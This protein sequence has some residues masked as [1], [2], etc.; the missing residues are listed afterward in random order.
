MEN[1]NYIKL[2]TVEDITEILKAGN[3]NLLKDKKDYTGKKIPSFQKSSNVMICRAESNKKD[4]SLE[5][6]L[7]VLSPILR[8]PQYSGAYNTKEILVFIYNF[9]CQ[10]AAIAD[11]FAQENVD[12][13]LKLKEILSQKDKNYA[14]DYKQYWTSV[15]IDED[16]NQ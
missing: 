6:I 14:E 3:F 8:N 16:E 15:E 11:E 1:K 7:E 4:G 12:M 10:V 13:T 9:S 5:K 2:L